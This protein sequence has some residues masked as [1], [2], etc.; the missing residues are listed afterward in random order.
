MKEED[1]EGLIQPHIDML[2]EEGHQLLSYGDVPRA[3]FSYD[4]SFQQIAASLGK[5]SPQLQTVKN[6][7]IDKILQIIDDL[8]DREKME[9][10]EK[11]LDKLDKLNKKFGNQYNQVLVTILDKRALCLK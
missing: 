7:Q 9:K 8:A 2:F 5:C 3:F 4:N 6:T 11:A 1:F 10:V